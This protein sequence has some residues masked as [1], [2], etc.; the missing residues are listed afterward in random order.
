[1]TRLCR[2]A[3]LL[4][5]LIPASLLARSGEAIQ[6]LNQGWRLHLHDGTTIPATMPGCVYTDLFNAGIIPDPFYGTNEHLVKWVSDS[7][8]KYSLEFSVSQRF[9]SKERLE[10]VFK[11]IDTYAFITLNGRFLF[12]SRN[13]FMEYRFP[14]TEEHI[15]EINLLEVHFSPPVLVSDSLEQAFGLSLPEDS[16]VFTRKGQ[17][18]YGWDW[19]PALPS[20]GLAG[21]VL[22]VGYDQVRI[23]D[24]HISQQFNGE[25]LKSI[26]AD[27]LLFS[28]GSYPLNLSIASPDIVP[29]DTLVM[30]Q[31]G[32]N[33]FSLSFD[34]KDTV[35]YWWPAGY[36]DQNLY[37]FFVQ[38]MS[39]QQILLAERRVITGIRK[40]ELV[41]E[42]DEKGE[43][44]YLRING[45]PIFA[46]GANWVPPDHFPARA[47]DEKYR[48]LI[49]EARFA[50]MNMLRV[51]G[52]GVYERDLFYRLC[53]S[54]GIMVWQDFM[55]ACGMYPDND[56]FLVSVMAEVEVQVT[57][58]RNH[59]SIVLFC[60]NNEV[61]EGWHRWGWSDRYHYDDSVKVALAY[62]II[63]HL[64]LPT[65]LA[66]LDPDMPY[67][68]TSPLLGRGDPDHVNRGSAHYWG[69]WHDGE[70]FS[71]FRE[72][73][74]RFMSEFGFQAYPPM[75][76]LREFIPQDQMHR[77][78]PSMAT[79]Q[80]H[81]RGDKLILQYM[82]EWFPEPESFE[83]FVLFSQMLQ[84]E[85]VGI[86]IL[87]HREAKPW[88]MGSLLWQFNDTWPA[89]S[90]SSVDYYGRRKALHY[91]VK[92]LFNPT[93]AAINVNTHSFEMVYINDNPSIDTVSVDV[94][95]MTHDGTVLFH[96][97]ELTSTPT[98]QN[99]RWEWPLPLT[100]GVALSDLLFVARVLHGRDTLSNS[101]TLPVKPKHLP[102]SNTQINHQVFTNDEGTTIKIWTDAFVYGVVLET[103]D[104]DAPFSD[105]FFHLLPG[106]TKTVHTSARLL[107]KDLR[108]YSV[109]P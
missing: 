63:F 7:T 77:G 94:T 42:P 93:L 56:G 89:I 72:K 12:S 76:S 26:S 85:G 17:W 96:H 71:M 1:M 31:M 20:M 49:K 91:K 3:L 46:K 9:T 78:S 59:P 67:I 34:L 14:I 87:A 52:G 75:A 66:E 6:V 101:V 40:S 60:G 53:D 79:H 64:L 30:T 106:E 100:E 62:K 44:F 109:L 4:L 43:S 51:W 28:T 70:P 88:C 36:G 102:L 82:N 74:P 95:V 10:L 73:V 35:R 41:R 24:V 25:A 108:I 2:L 86:G 58:L 29:A 99:R 69:V 97:R 103:A 84:A 107:H 16:R 45:V 37:E 19:A 33:R 5:I 105:N 27:F 22:L 57:R 55:F 13:Q 11:S 18:Q 92:E 47:T 15:K 61:S 104:G 48:R 23:M 32:I 81:T 38:V 90:W 65:M 50:G 8:W 80:K 54:A 98:T 21:D 68:H 83:Q 39:E